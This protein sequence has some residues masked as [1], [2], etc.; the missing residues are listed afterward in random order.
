MSKRRKTK[1]SGSLAENR[2][3]GKCCICG[4]RYNGGGHNPAPYMDGDQVCC[5]VCNSNVVIP[6]RMEYILAHYFSKPEIEVET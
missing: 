4:R 1:T 6:F 2:E 5:G 3:V